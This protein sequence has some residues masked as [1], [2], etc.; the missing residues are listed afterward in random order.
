MDKRLRNLPP[1]AAQREA[2]TTLEH[3]NRDLNTYAERGIYLTLQD[4]FPSD[5]LLQGMQ[6][7]DPKKADVKGFKQFLDSAE[8]RMHAEARKRKRSASRS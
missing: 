4:V 8:S 5:V 7:L 1:S 3:I 6:C 2:L